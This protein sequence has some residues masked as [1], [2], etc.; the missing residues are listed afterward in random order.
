M[1]RHQY[2]QRALA[3]NVIRDLIADARQNRELGRGD[4]LASNV[5]DIRKMLA[6]RRAD[7]SVPADRF[8][9]PLCLKE[10]R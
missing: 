1:R 4:D 9:W 10:D 2:T 8:G 6:A 7:G 5:H 3:N